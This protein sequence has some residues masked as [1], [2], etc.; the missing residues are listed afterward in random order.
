MTIY[1]FTLTARDAMPGVNL[2]VREFGNVTKAGFEFVGFV[3]HK[4]MRPDRFTT[5]GARALGLRK[6]QGERGG[7][8]VKGGFKASYTGRKLKE[9][10]H[11]KPN[12][13]S[14][15]S[16]QASRLASIRATKKSVTV[17]LPGLRDW[18]RR[19]P[20]SWDKPL[21]SQFRDDYGRGRITDEEHGK[22][23]KAHAQQVKTKL[24]QY[25]RTKR[26]RLK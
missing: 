12:V 13:W 17:S 21:S 26:I 14:G 24:R 3:Y 15:D 10:G 18:N 1:G 2:S 8:T 25:R 20:K 7:P 22:L 16:V 9:K 4:E 5:K 19:K 11:T 23:E 6:R